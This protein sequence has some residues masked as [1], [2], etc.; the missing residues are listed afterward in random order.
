M[1]RLAD[2]RP[3]GRLLDRARHVDTHKLL[4][5]G[6]RAARVVDRIGLVGRG[7]AGALAAL[8][9]SIPPP[10]KRRLCRLEPHRLL[11][12]GADHDIGAFRPHRRP[13]CRAPRRRRAPASRPP[14]RVVHFIYSARAVGLRRH[15]QLRDQLV[16]GQ[17]G[18]VIAGEQI[19][20]RH[21]PLALRPEHDDAPA[22]RD[23]ERRQV[24]MRVG[25]GQMAADGRDIAHPDV[26]QCAQRARRSPARARRIRAALERRQRRQRADPAAR[27]RPRPRSS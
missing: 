25:M 3:R 6:G 23:Q 22:E 9:S 27:H 7:L 5:V 24:H 12:R 18:L 17:H 21:R 14:S 20:D 19:L 11:G 4:L 2:R 16:L 10:F 15:D 26:G 13:R 8:A 1:R